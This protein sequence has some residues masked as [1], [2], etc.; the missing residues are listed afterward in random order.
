MTMTIKNKA[1]IC[2]V[3]G[4]SICES[5]IK[6]KG[7]PRQY[8]DECRQVLNAITLLDKKLGA[9]KRLKPTKEKRN[10]MRKNILSITNTRLN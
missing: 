9:F 8:H 6:K 5:K 4:N 3:C 1:L 2:T 10:S 7:R